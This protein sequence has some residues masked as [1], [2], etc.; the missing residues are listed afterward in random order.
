MNIQNSAV[1]E[2]AARLAAARAGRDESEA[3][4]VTAFVRT[5]STDFT[6]H[7]CG[8][9]STADELAAAALP[10]WRAA[11]GAAGGARA[12]AAGDNTRASD[13]ATYRDRLGAALAASSGDAS[14]LLR[15]YGDAFPSA[16]RDYVAPEGRLQPMR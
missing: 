5:H 15:R 8:V 4:S 13:A 11:A 10:L 6:P 16:Y 1:I 14:E 3:Q 2:A 12:R 7:H 9:G